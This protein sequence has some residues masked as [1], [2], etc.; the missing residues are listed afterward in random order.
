[1]QQRRVDLGYGLG[2]L[3]VTLALIIV[4]PGLLNNLLVAN[5]F[6]PHGHCYLWKPSLVWL[7]LLSD[8]LIGLAYVAISATLA[9]LVY[10]AR[11][12]IPFQ[13]VFLAFG[14]FI[15]AC[16]S[17]HFMEVW[18]LWTPVY[19]LSGELKLIT[20]VA[21]VTTA[22][23]LPP[24]VPQVLT[25]LET[26]KVSEE[27]KLRL[28]SANQELETLYEKLKQID[29]IKSQFF[30]NISHELRT[31]LAL[32]LGPTK[33]IL[34]TETLTP[35]Q[36]HNLEVV[37]NNAQI[38]LKHVNDL[39][40]I[41]KLE[42]QKMS[43]DYA[44]V[45]LAQLVRLT[46]A[47]FNALAQEL[48]ID[49]CVE[50]P[51]SIS[52]QIDPEKVQR[53]LSNLLANAFK[54]TPVGGFVRCVVSE[55]REQEN[56]NLAL[57]TVE[58]SGPGV[59]LEQQEAIF[60]RF[61][62]VDTGS[63]R[64]FGGTGL[65]LAIAKDFVELHGGTIAVG[66]A[67]IGGASF[68]VELP[69]LAPNDG[70]VLTNAESIANSE[71]IISPLLAELRSQDRQLDTRETQAQGN[72]LTQ[73]APMPQDS[74]PLVLVVED[75]PDMNRF[76]TEM[77]TPDYR[78]ASAFNGQ[79]GLEMALRLQPD[80]ILSDVMMPQ[81][82][83]DQ[84][85]REIRNRPELDA[86]PFVVLTAKADDR[87]RVQML[88]A[89]AQDYLMK[90]FSVEE[91]R[92]RV[93]NLI[94]MKRARDFL[95]QQLDS[96]N[97][98]VAALAQEA[99]RRG[100]ELQILTAQL[101]T[102]VQ[103]RTA[104]LVQ[105]N[106]YLQREIIERQQTEAAL[107]QSESTL[108]SFYNSASMMMGIVEL[109][110]TDNNDVRHICDNA[111]AAKWF[112][113]TPEAIQNRLASEMG[114]PAEYRRKWIEQYREAER[115]QA[116]VR[117]EYC[118]QTV[119]GVRWLSATVCPIMGI[120]TQGSNPS[121]LSV[122]NSQS[123]ISNRF[124]YIVEDISDRKQAE[125]ERAQLIR[126]QA[127]LAQAETAKRRFAFLAEASQI[128]AAS[129]DY[130]VT[131]KNLAHLA[132]PYLADCCITYLL[133]ED[134]T[135]Y[136]L[137]VAHVDSQQ[138]ELLG[139]LQRDNIID[140]VYPPPVVEV[141]RTGQPAFYPQVPNEP[142]NFGFQILD[143]RLAEIDEHQTPAETD[144]QP[145]NPKSKIQNLK[146][147]QSVLIVPMVLEGRTLGAISFAYAQ[148]G[149]RYSTDDLAVAEDLA[150][151][152]ALAVDKA[153]LY[154]QAQEAN[155][156]KDEFLA[157][158]SHELRTPINAI[159]GWAHLL[160]TRQLNQATVSRALETIERNART[161]TQMIEDLLDV[162]RI[163]QGKLQLNFCPIDL[164]NVIDVTL[165]AVRPAAGVK[166]IQLESVFDPN[167]GLVL[168]DSDRLQQVLW[169]LLSNAIKFTPEG[170]RVSVR[171]KKLQIS[172]G[173]LPIENKNSTLNLPSEISN[174]KLNYA[175]LQVSDSGI[176]I[177]PNFLPYVFDRF[178]QA[179]GSYT[180]SHGGLGL[181]LA[182]VR[183]LVELHG[184]TVFA[185]SPGEGQ[186]ATFTVQLPLHQTT[187]AQELNSES[188]DS[189]LA[190]SA[191]PLVLAG[192]QILL[193][194]DEADTRDFVAFVL[195]QEGAQDVKAVA[196]AR[197]AL[198]L[199]QQWRPDVLISDI[200]MP[201][202][203]GYTLMQKIRAL[204]AQQGGQIPSIALT[205]Y[206]HEQDRSQALAAGF[207]LHLSKPV[208]PEEL[209]NAIATLAGRGG[210]G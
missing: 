99:A 129:L 90:P 78:T 32:I 66:K 147:P 63:T 29:A 175:Q 167:V 209:V 80:L 105:T 171:L 205:A 77:L 135:I 4:W 31:P 42:A 98:D 208:E 106:T 187:D 72:F 88:Q 124:A 11:R 152:A 81:M 27:R 59:P 101:E 180:R 210:Y 122:P 76:I 40:D 93:G 13:W 12:N 61:S 69:L 56:F 139:Q 85:L 94:A 128:L 19:W 52:A 176:G 14:L 202:E 194:E 162:S 104:E 73:N 33:Q 17:T 183:H 146:L 41:A 3:A 151:R 39:L 200:G 179:D 50:T 8:T 113:L 82:S 150:Y 193:V 84:L 157:V 136:R 121:A 6:I 2:I 155:R 91:L 87:W 161:Q 185:E 97:Q 62:Q 92:S 102:R 131:L 203:N 119:E 9:Y 160:R 166:A 133:K 71:E 158:L 68:T 168:G 15:V 207:Q 143:L 123:P 141:L 140:P 51:A 188:E 54:F 126:E 189:D 114:V 115:T 34:T 156:I 58:D 38:L 137:A 112:G 138:K 154:R 100:H 190:L 191:Q 7:H 149:R 197:E 125:E 65:G 20:A 28:E 108:R 74:L 192:L 43:L 186:G 117:F 60:D 47:N 45:D 21:S 89:G 118:H 5:G 46:A 96:Q 79:E 165:D 16:G 116:P 83:G 144:N 148:S 204:E 49:F 109:T 10:K 111:T 153:Q 53:I 26:A 70:I 22:V 164:S 159:L 103:E 30:T 134:Q 201:G 174:L 36:R 48:Q 182:I 195:E 184:G 25:L 67:K 57:I 23:V 177:D 199:L 169:N 163:I 86:I 181:G 196:S 120:K 198:E 206:A 127:A 142:N 172:D 95:Q 37:D 18:T 35:Q 130:E 132:V 1:M 110:D 178:R 107:R 44:E 55:V 64:R 75:H 145:S 173:N 24:L 170:G